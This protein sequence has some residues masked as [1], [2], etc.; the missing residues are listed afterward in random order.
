VNF[1]DAAMLG[2]DL[3]ITTTNAAV[4]FNGTVNSADATARDLTVNAGSGNIR[5]ASTV[6]ATQALDVVTLNSS[7]ET[8]LDASLNV[9]SLTTNTA[10]LL[11]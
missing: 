9:G 2:A 4:L 11:C 8:R 3:T 7:G 10:V 6:G 5:F 1:N